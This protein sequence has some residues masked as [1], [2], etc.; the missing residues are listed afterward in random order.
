MIIALKKNN[1]NIKLP[2]QPTFYMPIGSNMFLCPGWIVFNKEPY[3]WDLVIKMSLS[4]NREAVYVRRFDNRD[5]QTSMEGECS[6]GMKVMDKTIWFYIENYF[7]EYHK[8]CIAPEMTCTSDKDPLRI[9]QRGR[10]YY[11]NG[12]Y[13]SYHIDPNDPVYGDKVELLLKSF[14]E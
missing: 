2:K 3:Y 6:T 4:L 1:M 14:K 7:N 8:E 13:L 11:A 9:I 12:D 10:T 5:L